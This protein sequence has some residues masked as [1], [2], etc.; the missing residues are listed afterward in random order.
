MPKIPTKPEPKPS[1]QKKLEPGLDLPK[2]LKDMEAA[3][4]EEH[5]LIKKT[6]AKYS[7]DEGLLDEYEDPDLTGPGPSYEDKPKS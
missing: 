3:L 7:E 4:A 1:D 2:F 6:P 5:E